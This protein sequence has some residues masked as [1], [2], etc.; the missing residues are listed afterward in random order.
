MDGFS[1]PRSQQ[2]G[3]ALKWSKALKSDK[4]SHGGVH[5]RKPA[6]AKPASAPKAQPAAPPKPGSIAFEK[7]IK[8]QILGRPQVGLVRFPRGL[9][10]LCLGEIQSLLS[11]SRVDGADEAHCE[12]TANCVQISNVSL[13]TL[14]ALTAQLTTARELLW[15]V[16][17]GRAG[18]IGEIKD[19]CAAV[20]WPLLLPRG[21]AL[22]LRVASL[23]SHVFHEGKVAE[24]VTKALAKHG[25]QE[26]P[27]A[28]AKQLLDVRLIEDRITFALSL[29]GRPLYQR[30]YKK[31]L[32]GTA[33]VKEDIAA[34]CI[35]ATLLFAVE[36]QGAD[37][38]PGQI[39]APFAG[40]G[41]LGFEAAIAL[42]R[43]PPWL[44]FG[45][46][47]AELFPCTPQPTMEF[48]RR[49]SLIKMHERSDDPI[50]VTFIEND[51]AQIPALRANATNFNEHLAAH[52]CEVVNF[53]VIHSDFFECTWPYQ[54]GSLLFAI[55]PPYGLRLEDRPH[56]ER[57]YPRLAKTIS[58]APGS[59]AGFVL[60]PTEAV[61]QRFAT[62]LK[63]MATHVRPFI[64]GGRTVY[65][66]VFS[67][68]K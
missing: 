46:L 31:T 22:G 53:S 13:R 60:A 12:L 9:G 1:T 36:Q 3:S 66:V 14:L 27:K 28:N 52:G 15:V 43:I 44:F 63:G 19:R 42:Q 40:S 56:I 48:M 23:A 47:G 24:L 57:L 6:P 62:G 58:G 61:A 37:F 34:A 2:K 59:L 16:G 4:S 30:R 32:V 35:R 55:N 51:A 7:L 54:P 25:I 33:T 8:R 39:L 41:T 10:D 21:A 64:H 5:A 45:P 65:L 50:A 11:N 17:E 49:A 67:R 68:S 38:R 29:A 20:P 18:S 26:V